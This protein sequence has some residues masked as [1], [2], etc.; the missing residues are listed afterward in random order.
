MT[1]PALLTAEAARPDP[2][3]GLFAMLREDV[4]C[5]FGRD[6]AARSTWEVLTTYPGLHAL[7][8]HRI[9]HRLWRAGWRYPA[10][11]LAFLARM[12]TNIDIHP[13]A[14]I[15]RRFFIDHGAGVVI[16]ETAE[17]GDDVTLY[18]GVT[19]G[20]TTW[21]KGKRH[22]TLGDGVVVGAGAKILGAIVIGA[23]ARIGANSV[24]V[25]DVPPGRTA[26]GIPARLVGERSR[27]AASG[28]INLDHH[29]IPDPVGKAI[30]CLVERI[31]TL[32]AEVRRLRGEPPAASHEHCEVC[33]AGEL[34]CEHAR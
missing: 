5:I 27:A 2:P 11:L 7:F 29:L 22:P 23:N 30:G 34:C 18:H 21:N 6:P 31:E 9:A 8:L 10:R 3:P 13:G 26:V 17:I 20:G 12:L 1:E 15:G 33:A 19:L 28:A 4:A 25:K 24:V 14:T 32:E 16:G